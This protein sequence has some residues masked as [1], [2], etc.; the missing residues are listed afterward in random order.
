MNR[1]PVEFSIGGDANWERG[2]LFHR[3]RKPLAGFFETIK[4]RTI[5]VLGIKPVANGGKH[6]EVC[7]R[8]ATQSANVSGE[9]AEWSAAGKVAQQET[10]NRNRGAATVRPPAADSILVF[11]PRLAH[12]CPR[13]RGIDHG[14]RTITLIHPTIPSL[15]LT[16]C[17]CLG[18]H[19]PKEVPTSISSPSSAL[20]Q[21]L[22][23]DITIALARMA[24]NIRHNIYGSMV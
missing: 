20:L 4:C 5:Q 11:A 22:F 3:L 8:R 9:L 7:P 24:W 18:N 16:R 23:A 1:G 21:L 15:C 2:A 14:A 12:W 13:V 6:G 19:H 10:G 17:A